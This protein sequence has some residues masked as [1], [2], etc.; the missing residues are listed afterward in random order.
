MARS[1][2]A[3]FSALWRAY[4]EGR[5]DRA[6]HLVDPDCE[7]TLPDGRTCRGHDGIRECLEV[8]RRDWRT[9]TITYDDIHEERPAIIVGIGRVAASGPEGRAVFERP[10]ACVA[11]FRDGRFV[12]GW[13]FGDPARALDHARTVDEER[14]AGEREAA[15]REASAASGSDGG[16]RPGRG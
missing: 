16:R 9:L 4:G 6:L 8:A 10:L 14:T 1:S 2:M 7:F 5:L 15:E 3:V 11:E 13:V 12:R